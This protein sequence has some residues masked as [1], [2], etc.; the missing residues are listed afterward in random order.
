[1]RLQLTYN[2]IDA[3]TNVKVSTDLHAITLEARTLGLAAPPPAAS[4]KPS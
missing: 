1:M 2:K 4:P 3:P